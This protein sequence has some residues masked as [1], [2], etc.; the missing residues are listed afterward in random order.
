[1]IGH[2]IMAFIFCAPKYSTCLA[3]GRVSCTSRVCVDS[4]YLRPVPSGD[5]C[6]TPATRYYFEPS[7]SICLSFDGGCGSQRQNDFAS[8][9]DCNK[10]CN[11]HSE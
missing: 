9:S 7:V 5:N 4:C 6:T 11:Q 1:M 2:A 3:S 10:S 8:L